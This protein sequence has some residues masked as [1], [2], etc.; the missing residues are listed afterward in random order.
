[1][2]STTS[3]QH[4]PQ[5][6]PGGLFPARAACHGCSMTEILRFPAED[7]ALLA[8]RDA[9]QGLPL[10]CLPGLT[11]SMADF[12][13]LAPHLPPLRLIRMD[14][15]GRGASAWTGA[16]TYTIAQEARDALALL[17]HLG[18]AKAAILGT[19]RGGLI[20]MVLAATARDRVMG[21]CLNDVGP[22]I[23]RDGLARISDYVGRNPAGRTQAGFADL[24]SHSPGFA[25]VPMSRWQDEARRLSVETSEGLRIPYDPALREAFLAAFDGPPIDLWPLFDALQ[26]LPLALIRGANSDLLSADCAQKMR[27][28][29]PDMDFA[30]VPDRA[31]IP[32]LDEPEAVTLIHTWLKAM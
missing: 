12:D 24:L 10:L 18:L 21:L 20:G 25:N 4:P 11:R 26:G 1:M 5:K 30:D 17:D 8:Y 29:R 31:H 23:N 2:A 15:R 13:Y 28:R 32:F 14:Y 27:L 9:G 6:P 16:A 7:G 19:S 22:E 3:A